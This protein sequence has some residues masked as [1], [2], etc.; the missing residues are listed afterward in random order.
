MSDYDS[1]T[2]HPYSFKP[3]AMYERSTP[4]TFLL[5]MSTITAYCFMA[6]EYTWYMALR[7]G[8]QQ[9]GDGAADGGGTITTECLSGATERATGPWH[10]WA[11][12]W[13]VRKHVGGPR[14]QR[15]TRT[16]LGGALKAANV[17]TA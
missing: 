8:L 13:Q 14:D 6:G 1:Q 15:L 9:A 2:R 17:A 10:L 16:A 11:W 5:L 7:Y 4:V 12:I 3:A